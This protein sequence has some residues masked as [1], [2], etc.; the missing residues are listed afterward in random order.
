MEI[1]GITIRKMQEFLIRLIDQSEMERNKVS[2]Q[3]C[4]AA[5]EQSMKTKTLERI[6][7][8]IKMLRTIAVAT[9]RLDSIARMATDYGL[10]EH[11]FPFIEKHV[12]EDPND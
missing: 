4:E 11:E 8:D 2:D 7:S 1:E 3:I 12:R 10:V 6:E 5:Y 9:E